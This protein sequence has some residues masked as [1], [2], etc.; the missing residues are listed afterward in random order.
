[1]LCH[2]TKCPLLTGSEILHGVLSHK[3]IRLGLKRKKW[4]APLG[5]CLELPEMARK[6]NR[7]F[8]NFFDP[9]SQ[10]LHFTYFSHRRGYRRV[11]KFCMGYKWFSQLKDQFEKIK[12][13]RHLAHF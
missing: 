12:I 10:T 3:K 4:E 13:S 6:L 2:G 8:S 7:K 1:M 9:P 5:K 11:M